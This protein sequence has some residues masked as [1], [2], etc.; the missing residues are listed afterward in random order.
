MTENNKIYIT[1]S[2]LADMLGVSVGHAYKLVRKLNQE[3]EKDGFLVIAGKV[4]R[5]YFENVGMAIVHR[6]NVNESRKR[7]ENRKMVNSVSLYRLA[8]Q[9]PKIYEKRLCYK[10]RSGG[11][12]EKFSYY[13]KCRF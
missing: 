1:A 12:A 6:R 7:Q 5:R 13:T 2:E 8:G 11:M 3:L 4:P 9:T 10:K